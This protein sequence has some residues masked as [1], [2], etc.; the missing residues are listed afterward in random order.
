MCP[1]SHPDFYQDELERQ[2]CCSNATCLN[3]ISGGC[4]SY[5]ID[6]NAEWSSWSVCSN[7]VRSRQ[8]TC[9]G[10]VCSTQEQDCY[11]GK[12]SEVQYFYQNEKLFCLTN[13]LWM[14]VFPVVIMHRI[15]WSARET[16]RCILCILTILLRK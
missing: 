8:K 4:R 15:L 6:L 7:G 1:F 14:D 9:H 11:L 16:S 3:C 10:F 2:F 12:N 5:Q 13:R